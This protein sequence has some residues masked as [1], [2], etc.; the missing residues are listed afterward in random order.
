MKNRLTRQ[1]LAIVSGLSLETIRQ[2]RAGGFVSPENGGLIPP[3]LNESL[4]KIQ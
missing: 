1:F 2:A 4:T 3:F